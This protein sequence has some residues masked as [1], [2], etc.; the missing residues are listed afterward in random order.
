MKK[1]YLKKYLSFLFEGIK[2]F[3][4]ENIQFFLEKNKH[5]LQK[6]QMIQI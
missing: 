3:H 1:R 2:F 6:K 5:F 4:F